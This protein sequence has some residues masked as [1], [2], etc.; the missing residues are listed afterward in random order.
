MKTIQEKIEESAD[1]H[2]RKFTNEDKFRFHIRKKDYKA[3]ANFA[4]PL[5]KEEGFRLAISILHE[6]YDYA[7]RAQDMAY[8]LDRAGIRLGII[9]VIEEGEEK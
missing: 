7:A 1:R 6:K 5:A 8:V 4:I 9:P 2:A 3:G